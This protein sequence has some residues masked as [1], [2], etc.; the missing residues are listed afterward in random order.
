MT[1]NLDQISETLSSLELLFRPVIL[2]LDIKIIIKKYK[3]INFNDIHIN[4][5]FCTGF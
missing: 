2:Q 3:T 5:T 1:V 4:L